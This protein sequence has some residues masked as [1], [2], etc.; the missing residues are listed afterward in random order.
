MEENSQLP[1][2]EP[3]PQNTEQPQNVGQQNTTKSTTDVL[4]IVSIVLAFTGLQ[5][6]GFIVGL[7]GASKAKKEDYSPI[8]SRIG[9]IINLAFGI[10][11]LLAIL[12]IF[13][14]VP[15]LQENQRET[16]RQNNQI[17]NN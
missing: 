4:G 9:W 11:A 1:P 2:P 7:I 6:I 14:A 13:I 5:L 15:I 8:L 10:I 16:L 17:L 12:A 3:L